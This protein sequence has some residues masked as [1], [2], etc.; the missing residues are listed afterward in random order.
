[1][2]LAVAP[3]P[4]RSALSSARRWRHALGYA[5]GVSEIAAAQIVAF[6]LF[7]V[8]ESVDL[9]AIPGL[10]SGP[11]VPA[12][13][14]PKPATP[15]YVQYDK[16]PLTF[17]G[18]AVGVAEID[19]F[20]TRVRVYD[21]GVIS[22]GLLRPF[23]GTW[24]DLAELAQ[25]LI[26]NDEIEQRAE[27]FCRRV[28]ERLR[29]GRAGAR[30]TVLT[31]DYLVFAVTRLDRPRG[32]E[33]LIA[34]QGDTIAAILRGER[35]A[36]SQQERSTILRHRISYLEDDLVVPTWNAAFVYD[37]SAG[38]QAA[39][40]I[41]EF[42]NSQL[43]EFRH[44]DTLLDDQLEAIYA[45][46]QHPRWYD[47]WIGSRYTRAARRVHSLFIDVNELTDRTENAVKFIGD[48]YAVRLFGLIAGRLGLDKW[49]ADVEAKLKTLDDIYRFAVE[50][51]SMSRGQFLE[52]TIVLIL[53]FELIL[54]FMGVM[55]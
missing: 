54:I 5:S 11:A 20:R 2:N 31:E 53:I 10:V 4:A 18:E 46:L 42:A 15:A 28:M 23:A 52:L 1:V 26:E 32:A 13:L 3:L 47:K 36:L 8:A 9:R 12:R 34:E 16:P 43:L 29:P 37:T 19:G 17:D 38:A 44:Y 45:Q 21:Y 25:T 35:Q 7:D 48:I 39:L 51:T 27:Q 40:E 14:A 6:Y 22:V 49:K 41:A 33:E 50:Q 55:R 30:A 24:A